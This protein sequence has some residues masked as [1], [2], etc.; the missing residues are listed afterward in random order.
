MSAIRR[1]RTSSKGIKQFGA[2]M[3]RM[4]IQSFLKNTRCSNNLS[5]EYFALQA[6]KEE[7]VEQKFY[8]FLGM[9]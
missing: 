6:K 7:I 2:W 5:D 4:K 1:I 9:F 8:C 3:T